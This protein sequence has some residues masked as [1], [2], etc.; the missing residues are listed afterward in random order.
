MHAKSKRLKSLNLVNAINS[1][2][3]YNCWV[4]HYIA[5]FSNTKI[6]KKK[7]TF[8]LNKMRA[9]M[10]IYTYKVY[11]SSYDLSL[12]MQKMKIKN[13]NYVFQKLE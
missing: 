6:W 11:E 9:S 8:Y 2:L 12:K 13:Y 3:K 10:P 5:M 4:L 7:D 1:R